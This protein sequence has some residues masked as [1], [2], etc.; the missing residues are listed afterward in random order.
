M[1]SAKIGSTN[2]EYVETGNEPEYFITHTRAERAGGGNLRIYGYNQR[3]NE[4]RLVYT[5]IVPA[6]ALE[7]IARRGL[8]AAT[9]EANLDIWGGDQV[10]AAH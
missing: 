4:L 2:F 8:H 10:A 7:H 6:T 3:G 9:E 1:G 5:V